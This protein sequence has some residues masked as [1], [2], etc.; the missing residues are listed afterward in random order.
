MVKGEIQFRLHNRHSTG[1]MSSGGPGLNPRQWTD[2][3]REASRTAA[4]ANEARIAETRSTQFDSPNRNSKNVQKMLGAPRKL[5]T[6]RRFRSIRKTR[7]RLTFP[8]TG[9][10]VN[11]AVAASN[12]ST[13]TDPCTPPQTHNTLDAPPEVH[14]N[15]SVG[16]Q[17]TG[18]LDPRSLLF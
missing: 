15:S 16:V 1:R 12:T 8:K 10:E 13:A 7:H 11:E 6:F 17:R 5:K 3:Q 2:R 18:Q 14:R 9:T 4:Q